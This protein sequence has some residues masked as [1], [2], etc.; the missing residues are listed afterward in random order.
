MDYAQVKPLKLPNLPD[1]EGHD[2]SSMLESEPGVPVLMANDA[3][4]AAQREYRYGA[5]RG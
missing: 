1:W 4:F 2:S 5:G 3:D